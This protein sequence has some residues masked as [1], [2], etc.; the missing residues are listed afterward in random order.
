MILDIIS[1]RFIPPSIFER[2]KVSCLMHGIVPLKMKARMV[3]LNALIISNGGS[4]EVAG[5]INFGSMN[6]F[7][8]IALPKIDDCL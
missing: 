8:S 6:V 4:S 1:W 7:T 3:F 2:I 5:Y